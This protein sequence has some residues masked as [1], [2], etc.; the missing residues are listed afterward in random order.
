MTDTKRNKRKTVIICMTI[1]S[2]MVGLSYAS[3]PLYR[4]FC[5]VTGWGGTPSQVA[6]NQSVAS[7]ETMT[8]RFD[9]SV[10]GKMPWSFRPQEHS[11]TVKVGETVLAFY[12]A[13]NPTAR[14]TAGTATFNVLP[15]KAGKY[16]SKIDCFCFTE[17]TLQPGQ[18]VDMPVT[19]FVDPAI[20]TDPQ[21][22]NVREITLS[23]TF[24]EQD[25]PKE[26][27]QSQKSD[28]SIK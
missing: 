8:I 2:C 1:F 26:V 5:Q 16:F 20:L 9:A 17:Q 11:M 21:T 7:Q 12:Q 19:F 18:M 6:E 10:S 23:Y 28:T 13:K 27:A 25:V 15:N 4:L 24:F 14:V 3:V 22:K